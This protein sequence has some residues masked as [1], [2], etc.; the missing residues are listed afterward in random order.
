MEKNPRILENDEPGMIGF[1]KSSSSKNISLK[2]VSIRGSLEGALFSYV[3]NQDYQ[4]DTDET[5]EI[6]YTFP[7]G[8]G[9]TLLGMEAVIGGKKLLGEVV[10]NA[11][12]EERYEKAVEKGDSAIMVQESSLGLYTANLGN[13]KPGEKVGVDI[14]CARFLNYEG[15]RLRLAI[16]TVIGERYGDE[17]SP[18]GLAPHESA[19]VDM[20]ARYDFNLE[21]EIRGDLAKSLPQCPTHETIV[22]KGEDGVKIKLA[23]GASLDR[24]FV[25]LIKDVKSRAD[26]LCARDGENWLV[27]AGFYPEMEEAKTTPIGLKILVDCSGSMSGIS[28]DQAKIGLRKVSRLLK[29][30]DYV[31]FSRFG[32][33]VRHLTK[34]TLKCD[35]A[36]LKKLTS[37]IR[38]TGADMGG[39]EMEKAVLAVI[40]DIADKGDAPPA[41]LL[42]TD[43][44]IWQIKS[45]IDAAKKSDHKIF[46]VGVGAAPAESVLMELAKQTGGVCEFVTPNENMADAIE[47]MFRRMR[48]CAAKNI[49]VDWS[50]TPIWASKTPRFIY[51]DETTR[52][53]ALFEKKPESAPALFWEFDGKNYSDKAKT[54][55]ETDN[56]DVVRLGRKR[57]MEE[58]KS[59]DEKLTI[60]LK[61]RLVSALT[62]LILV[63]ERAENDKAEGIPTVR[64]VPQQPAYGHGNY[65]AKCISNGIMGACIPSFF[66]PKFMSFCHDSLDCASLVESDD[67]DERVAALIAAWKNRVMALK[68]LDEFISLIRADAKFE[69]LVDEVERVAKSAGE[70]EVSVWAVLLEALLQNAGALDRHSRRLLKARAPGEE[71]KMAILEELEDLP[72]VSA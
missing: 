70:N 25:L 64:H 42:I 9:T 33:N 54:L 69:F 29:P 46:V 50:G 3:I 6:I 55:E 18:G 59:D 7:V 8:Y 65:Q 31:S 37:A 26:A 56:H 15:D 32:N 61:Y 28:I 12:A 71:K 30:E 57:Q 38:G 43:G 35:E 19:K 13:I 47:R 20:N 5:L 10:K 17:H 52:Q 48:G 23:P 40:N 4:N 34:K 60:A 14:H 1:M 36:N 11:D 44:D 24:D 16:P 51:A 53:F 2:A 63:Y 58:A 39:T 41:I 45:L 49:R 27:C 66:A 68:S 72:G 67:S 22:E 21:L 62:S